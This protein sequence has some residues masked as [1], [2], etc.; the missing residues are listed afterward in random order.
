MIMSP[1]VRR[2][3]GKQCRDYEGRKHGLDEMMDTYEALFT[4]LAG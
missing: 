2:E 1:D 4:R 3:M